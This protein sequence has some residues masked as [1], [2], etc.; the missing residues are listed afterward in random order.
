[1]YEVLKKKFGQNFLIDQNI[2][3]KICNLIPNKFLSIIE[4]GPGNGRLTEHIL[5]LEP[6]KF[7]IIEIDS[8]LI[9]IIKKKFDKNL[10][11]E[12]INENI[13]N[14]PLIE[15]V[16]L[17][18]SN[19][20]YNISSQILVKICLT[21]HPPDILILMFQKEFAERLMDEKL[22]SLNSLVNC[23]YDIKNNFNVGKNCFRPK[24]KIN[25]TV[26]LFE[27]KKKSLLKKNEIN[28]FI[29]FKRILFSH[30]RKTLGNLLRNYSLDKKRFNLNLR[31][32]DLYLKNLIE[33]FRAINL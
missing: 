6:K 32:E 2:I 25:S 31:V 20:P 22:N 19:L 16:D 10:N 17:I 11:L 4:I 7:K 12:I 18:I 8:D 1:M 15:K 14:Y 23:F 28:D 26:L 27:R 29:D 3:K 5:K 13:L 33:I 21:K 30:K 9:P 24:P